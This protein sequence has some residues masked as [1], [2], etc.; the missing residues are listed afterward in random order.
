MVDTNLAV[1]IFDDCDFLAVVLLQN[2]IEERGF[3]RSKESG[4]NGDWDFLLSLGFAEELK[5]GVT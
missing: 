1:L 4:Q 5:T 2:P 3:A